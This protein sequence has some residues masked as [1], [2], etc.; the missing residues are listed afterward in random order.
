MR[1]LWAVDHALQ[2]QS[3]KMSHHLGITGPQRLVL[4][5]VG[6]FPGVLA[7]NLARLLCLHPSTVTGIV[8]RLEKRGLIQRHTDG[9]DR[10]RQR[11][12]VTPRGA[13]LL[14][15]PGGTVESATRS[16]LSTLSSEEIAATL[17]AFAALELH[18]M[19]RAKTASDDLDA[20]GGS[21]PLN[22]GL[23]ASRV[24]ENQ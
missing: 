21:K 20:T 9:V 8:N 24:R 3:I 4:R 23:H 5:L 22:H 14:L 13:E 6:R 11:L 15:A 7:G 17:K 10:R 12:L 16:A 18:L 1:R 19:G 2:L